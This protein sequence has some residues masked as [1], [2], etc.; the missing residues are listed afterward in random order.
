MSIFPDPRTGL[1]QIEG[2]ENGRGLSRSLKHRDWRRANRQADEFAS[3]FVGLEIGGTA[4]AKPEPLTLAKLFDIYAGR[5][6]PTKGWHS[7]GHDQAAM[8]MFL[9]LFGQNRDPAILSQRD[10]DRCIRE[11]RAGR[12]GPSGKPV[13]DRT[14]EYDL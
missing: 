5:I 9:R 10:W 7:W 3:G 8:Y 11:R 6:T 2:R 12:T 14:I 13:S 4:E 1:F